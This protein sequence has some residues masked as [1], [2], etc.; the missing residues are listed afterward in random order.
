MFNINR[1][2]DH[3]TT[4]LEFIRDRFILTDHDQDLIQFELNSRK[5]R[6]QVA[7]A[8]ITATLI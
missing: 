3:S 2:E 1:I 8:D 4:E 6:E 5:Y 7:I